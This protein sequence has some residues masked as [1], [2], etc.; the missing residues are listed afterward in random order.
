MSLHLKYRPKK[1]GEI[2][3]NT[4]TVEI[5]SGF[6]KRE[7][8]GRPHSYLFSGPKGCGK[9]S[10]SRI[11]AN[12]FGGSGCQ[13]IEIDAG[14]ER[15]VDTADSLRRELLYMPLF[16]DAKCYII[17]EIQATSKKFQE[18]LLKSLE[19][20]PLHVYFFLCT[21]HP[22]KIIATIKDRCSMF[23]MESLPA[24][25]IIKLLK[26]VCR[27]EDIKISLD[28]LKKIATLDGV[29]PRQSLVLLDQ[30]REIE[31]DE[32]KIKELR[33]E[34]KSDVIDLCRALL[35]GETWNR[36]ASLL[37]NIDLDPETVRKIII[38]YMSKAIVGNRAA[39]AAN[40]I[41][42]FLDPIYEDGK[43]KLY[44]GCYRLSCEE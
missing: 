21:T 20:T 37:G 31:R 28:V 32:D 35:S 17:D 4:K 43:V 15:G 22:E 1:L 30:I 12:E 11:L 26:Y 23:A 2:L 19:D 25:Y 13:I 44:F 39:R 42:W 34:D 41:E 9:T 16:G 14:S 8:R 40:I 29:S 7:P 3:G 36:V 24:N 33:Q 10:I 27:A 18:A 6:L 38:G 5:L